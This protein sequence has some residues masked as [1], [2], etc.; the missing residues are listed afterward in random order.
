LGHRIGD[1]LLAEAARRIRRCVRA[2]DTVARQ[3]GDEFIVILPN[4]ADAAAAGQVARVIIDA[5]CLPFSLDG[6]VAYVSASIGIAL[7][8]S[9]TGELDTLL[10]YADQAM[11]SAKADGRNRFSYFVPIFQERAI[12]RLELANDLRQAIARNELQLYFQPIIELGCG[13]V[14]KA[15]ALLRWFHPRHGAVGPDRFIPVAEEIGII[16]QIGDWVFRQAA[17]TARRWNEHLGHVQISVNKSPRQF[18][19]GNSHESWISYL[20]EIGLS[21]EHI[22]VEITEGLLLDQRPEVV[23]KLLAFRDAGIQVSLDDF[24]TG[25]S[26]MSYL[27]KF[28]IDYLKIDK[29]FVRDMATDPSDRAIAEAII[30]MA[31][32]LGIKV[33]AEGVESAE[34]RDILLAAGCDYAQGY[35]FAKPMPAADFE[36]FMCWRKTPETP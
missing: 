3:G 1:L 4:V 31:H 34:Q 29:S 8:P 16:N 26:A 18:L 22:A 5:L 19:T 25:Y 2:S 20:H 12:A 11:Y 28:D 6:Q 23:T 14:T 13:R 17:S 36:A 32:K 7:H 35:F 27:K 9:D 30:L 33:I 10:S 21:T 15:E 24:G